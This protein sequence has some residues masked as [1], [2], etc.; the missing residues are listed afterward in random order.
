MWIVKNFAEPQTNLGY[1]G[2][3][4]H[5]QYNLLPMAMLA[6]AY[7]RA[8]DSIAERPAP[9]EVGG[10]VFD[11]RNTFHKVA[12][13]AGGYYILI[14]TAADAHYNAT[15]LQRVHRV[16]VPFPALSDSA[17]GDRAYGPSE[18]PKAAIALGIEWKNDEPSAQWLSLAEFTGGDGERIVSSVN[19]DVRSSLRDRV[20]FEL[21]YH[22]RSE[23][24]RER[25]VREK[26]VLTPGAV[27]QTSTVDGESG[28][29]RAHLPVLVSDGAA[30]TAVELG[31]A[32]VTVSQ[33]GSVTSVQFD[34]AD[35][36]PGVKLEGPRVVTHNGYV[37]EAVVG[38][39][40]RSVTARITLR[41]EQPV[42]HRVK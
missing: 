28:A 6:I 10:Y 25:T 7:S 18:A 37:Q 4:F 27:E 5:S 13:A 24:Q 17:A 39:R 2:Y 15:G 12:A 34:P 11:V 29:F 30:D 32:S 38:A 14:D 21:T 20:E 1:E 42:E 22:L 40:S 26:Y 8:D 16:G 31:D 19:L 35:V 9:A 33:R 23:G 36:I 41:Q 3:S